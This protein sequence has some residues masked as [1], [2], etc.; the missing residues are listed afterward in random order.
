MTLR[1][2]DLSLAE[3]MTKLNPYQSTQVRGKGTRETVFQ[4]G[5]AQTGSTIV[6][7]INGNMDFYI[8]AFIPG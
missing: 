6:Q 1:I 3:S 5:D 2:S 8:Y 7:T 4:Y